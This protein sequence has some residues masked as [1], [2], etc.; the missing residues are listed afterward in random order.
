MDPRW[1]VAAIIAEPLRHFGLCS[2]AEQPERIDNLLRQ[3]GLDP[4]FATRYPHELSGGQRQRLAIA[5]AL[6]AE[7]SLLICDEPVSALDVSVQAQIINLLGHLRDELGLGIVFIAHD[8]AVVRHLADRVLV[9]YAGRVVEQ[10]DTDELFAN[11]HHPYTQA[12]LASIPE[13]DPARERARAAQPP[14]AGEAGS[15]PAPR[16]S[17]CTTLSPRNRCMRG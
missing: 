3:V 14:V 10:A 11:P 8:L 9:L 13:P 17:I 1:T 2:P 4:Q 15:P 12:L 6:A 5:R 16:L 7:P